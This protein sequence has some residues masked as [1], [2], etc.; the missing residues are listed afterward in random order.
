VSFA[1][2]AAA[3]AQFLQWMHQ[4]D[5]NFNFSRVYLM[6]AH[7]KATCGVALRISRQYKPSPD[8]LLN[9]NE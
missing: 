3:T 2:V 8:N 5:T 9:I 4:Q 7:I 1:V 6:Y